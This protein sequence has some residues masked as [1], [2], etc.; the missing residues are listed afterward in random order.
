MLVN[1]RPMSTPPPSKSSDSSPATNGQAGLPRLGA[2]DLGTN[3][4]RMVVAEVE[5]D[6]TYRVL[7]EEREMTRL[8]HR[9]FDTGRLDGAAMEQSLKALAR[10]KAITEGFGVT[11][12]RAVATSA[13]REASNGRAFTREALRRCGLRIEVISA[14]EEAQL[15]FQS[16][17][18]HFDLAG[19]AVAIADIGGGSMEVVFAA[20]GVVEQVHSLPLGAVRLTERYLKSDPPRPRE[21]EKL[22]RAIDRAL[23]AGLGKAPFRPELL[24]GSGGTFTNLG[25]MD[26]A[27]RDGGSGSIHGYRMTRAEIVHLVRRLREMPLAVRR[28]TPGLNPGRADIIV[29]GISAVSR[30]V[31]RLGAEQIAVNERGVRDGL[32]LSMIA[33]R[34]APVSAPAAALDRMARVRS[35]AQACRSNAHHCEH[36]ASLA[37]QLFDQLQ[38]RYELPAESRDLLLAAALLHDVGYLV[39]HARHHKHAYHLIMHANLDGFTP[40]EV[41]LIANVARYHRR[42]LPKKRHT[43]FARLERAD[44]R[45]VKRLGGILR[46]ADGLDRTHTGRVTAVRSENGRGTMRLRIDAESDPQV[47]IWDAERKA[48]LFRDAFG[49][50]VRFSWHRTARARPKLVAAGRGRRVAAGS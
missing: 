28:E 37:G 12:L 40:R 34:T 50:E 42:A 43:N 9:L 23:E 46:V 18:R 20:G 48:D 7:D 13:V 1:V 4:I 31:K 29:A 19:R 25:E 21:V 41:E 2:I 27:E 10:M 11:E 8:G 6:G 36:V 30:L 38:E 47:E 5:V 26:R 14:E 33:E 35:F 32:L 15:V 49:T 39:N 3:S 22:R 17:Q 16:V 45:L 24:I 44:R